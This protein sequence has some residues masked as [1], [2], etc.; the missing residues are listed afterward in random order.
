MPLKILINRWACKL[1]IIYCIESMKKSFHNLI[2]NGTVI[3][4]QRSDDELRIVFCNAMKFGD[5]LEYEVIEKSLRTD[6]I[7]YNRLIVW[8]L[9]CTRDQNYLQNYFNFL[10]NDTFKQYVPEIIA[11]TIENKIGKI[12][13]LEMIY[14]RFEE[15]INHI[16]LDNLMPLFESISTEFDMK[17]VNY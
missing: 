9:G 2:E 10:L 12:I 8:A 4:S 15:I 17:M 5:K 3:K 14:N 13:L 11:S 6:N 1:D 16:A 7:D